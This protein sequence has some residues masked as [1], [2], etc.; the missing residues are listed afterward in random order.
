MFRKRYGCIGF[1]VVIA[2]SIGAVLYCTQYV[3]IERGFRLRNF[4]SGHFTY[5][6]WSY[7]NWKTRRDGVLTV[8]TY[9]PPY[10]VLLAIRA[11]DPRTATVEI[12]QAALLDNDGSRRSVITTLRD[13][14]D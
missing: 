12:I 8:E 14:V 5:D 3:V 11:D 9:E 10:T 2:L 4:Q 1:C 7:G 13:R 6:V